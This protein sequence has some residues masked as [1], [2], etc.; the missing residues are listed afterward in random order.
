M[1]ATHFHELIEKIENTKL[2]LNLHV[3]VVIND[4]QD[5]V[6]LYKIKKGGMPR[7]FGID[8]AKLA[9]LPKEVIDESQELMN[10]KN[11]T[12]PQIS[13][14]DSYK[15]S[16]ERTSKNLS[17]ENKSHKIIIDKLENLNIDELSPISALLK[18]KE[19]KDELN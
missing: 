11:D 16:E 13:L 1:F 14:F 19:M 8:V 18:L 15:Y 10:K 17:D 2:A 12:N 3:G 4:N 9:G 7:S 6:F 5:P